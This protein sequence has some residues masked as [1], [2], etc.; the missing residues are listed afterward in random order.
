MYGNL[1]FNPS[2]GGVGYRGPSGVPGTPVAKT[3]NVRPGVKFHT[4]RSAGAQMSPAKMQNAARSANASVAARGGPGPSRIGV[5]RPKGLGQYDRVNAAAAAR[6]KSAVSTAAQTAG[7]SGK[8]GLLAGISNMSRKTKMGVGLGLGVA[9]AVTMNRRGEGASS[10]RQS[11][12]R[13]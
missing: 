4:P 10:G 2:M 6:R 13:Y 12:Y 1:V 11:I 7:G 8:K 9:A 3:G 5:S